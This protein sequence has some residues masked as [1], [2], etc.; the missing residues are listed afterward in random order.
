MT[1]SRSA[2]VRAWLGALVDALG[3]ALALLGLVP[4]FGVSERG[5]REPGGRA[6]HRAWRS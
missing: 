1:A 6:R 3:L 4:F 5:S 2:R